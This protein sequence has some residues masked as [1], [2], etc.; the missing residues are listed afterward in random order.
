M[1]CIVDREELQFG[2]VLWCHVKRI[3][4]RASPGLFSLLSAWSAFSFENN[5]I[6]LYLL[7]YAN[8]EKNSSYNEVNGD[9]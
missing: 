8:N 4:A 5:S 2:D 1:L 3:E 6:F 9:L 7:A